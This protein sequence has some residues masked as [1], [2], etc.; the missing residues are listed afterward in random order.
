MTRSQEETL[1]A[2][3]HELAGAAERVPGLA[4]AAL[5]QGRRLRRRRRAATAGGATLAVLALVTPFLL[6]RP[7]RAAPDPTAP[8]PTV[9]PS[10]VVHPTPGADWTTRPLVLPGGWVVVGATSTGTPARTGYVLNRHRDTYLTNNRYEEVWAAP[11][12][13][14]AVAVDYDRPQE[15]GLVDMVTGRVR[16]VRTGQPTLNPHW[17]PD[18]SRLVLTLHRKDSGEDSFGVLDTNGR[19]RTFPVDTRVRYFCTDWC[20]FTW[21][22]DGREVML[23]QTDPAAQLSESEPHAR[24]GVQFFSADDG[25]PTRF[26]AMPGDPAGPWAWSPDG[27]LVVVKGQTGPL[28]VEVATG[29]V[30]GSAPAE[31]AVWVGNDRLLYRDGDGMVLTRLDGQKLER[32]PLP[33]ELGF[34]QLSLAPR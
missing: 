13:T 6:L 20:V 7:E 3:V 16:W 18:G 2:V 17:S 21:S 30:W 24:R 12:G 29:K 25:R 10:V 34:L 32:Q 26:V 28:L 22:P 5:T 4:A 9:T 27:R 14:V 19:F 1:R 31:D 15:T 8:T 11:R 23:Q 33:Q